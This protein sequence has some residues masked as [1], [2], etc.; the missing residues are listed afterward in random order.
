MVTKV[1]FDMEG[2]LQTK[3]SLP[4]QFWEGLENTRLRHITINWVQIVYDSVDREQLLLYKA[5][6]EMYIP[7]KLFYLDQAD[8]DN[9]VQGMVWIQEDYSHPFYSRKGLSQCGASY[10]S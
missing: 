4:E 6:L 9:E 3:Y 2:Q 7:G 10:L 5:K 1:D 8:N